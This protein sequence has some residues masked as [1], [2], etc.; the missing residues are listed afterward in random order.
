MRNR[1]LEMQHCDDKNHKVNNESLSVPSR[2][3][4]EC[5]WNCAETLGSISKLNEGGSEQTAH[6][7]D[8]IFACQ[9]RLEF[10]ES[11]N[12]KKSFYW[13]Q[14]NFNDWREAMPKRP[15]YQASSHSLFRR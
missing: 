3:D 2:K 5:A 15:L 13:M 10:D 6:I 8:K 7:R 1:Q 4:E 9:Q 12:E 14:M 11:L